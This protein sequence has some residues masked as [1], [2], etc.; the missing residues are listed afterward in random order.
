MAKDLPEL[1]IVRLATRQHGNVT[2]QQLL[3]LGL[4]SAAIHHRLRTGRL[5]RVHLG[6]YAVGRP[7]KTVLERAAA[8]VLAAG[9]QAVLSHTSALALWGFTKKRWPTVFEVTI[10]NGDRRPRGVAVHRSMTLHRRDTRTHHGI[11][12]TSPART[13]LDCAPALTDKALARAVNDALLSKH[14]S[15]GQLAD[16]MARHPH[17]RAAKRLTRFIDQPGAP[18]RSTFEDEF[19]AFCERHGLPRPATNVIVAGHEVDALFEP[20]KLIV[21]L[22]SYEFHAAR[23]RFE[24]DRDRD[25]DTLLAGYRTV[26]ATWDRVH[27]TPNKEANRLR[28]LLAA[29]T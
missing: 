15:N 11:R 3:A 24:G 17:H 20:Q 18:T 5:H 25:A 27:R 29:E 14:L 2:R 4:G 23:D 12:V 1:A 22:D 13:I 9:P 10:V 8:A 21:E 6:V 28:A 16:T 7:P 26:R 19:V